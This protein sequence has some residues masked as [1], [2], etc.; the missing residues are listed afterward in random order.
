[1]E[2]KITSHQLFTFSALS[3]LGGS[4]LV[5]SSSVATVAK[6]DAWLSALVA[7]AAGLLMMCIY[8]YLGSRYKGVTLI[9]LPQKI[10]GKW[11]GK[12]V[13]AGYVLFMFTTAYGVPWWIGNFGAHIMHET[14]VPIIILPYVIAMVI[15]VYYGIESI[16]RASEFFYPFVT[17]L[18]VGSIILVLPNAKVEYMT[19]V[20]ENGVVP[21]LKGSFALAP[22]IIFVAIVMLM[23]YPINI[24]DIKSGRKA[25]MKGYL[26]CSTVVLITILVSVLVLGSAIVAKSS[27]PT[28]LLVKEINVENFLTRFEY[29]I[30]I[31]WIITEFMV[32]ILFFY[33]CI[34]GLSELIG[35]KD[36]K[37]IAVPMGL[38]VF[39]LSW[40]VDPSS[41]EQVNWN[42]FGFNPHSSLFGFILPVL[43]LIVFAIK[44]RIFNIQ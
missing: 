41:I 43:M 32:G 25:I 2:N 40:S 38:V 1:M 26:W 6:Q 24:D 19:P 11:I 27:F 15:G 14:P 9:G 36:H 28:L 23:I 39:I 22:I 20:L 34:K 13:A 18:F 21:I 33:T 10:F 3:I 16:A 7:M 44:K 17:I 12:I 35:L 4:L 37:K 30:S 5:V 42:S 8:C 31:M 29:A